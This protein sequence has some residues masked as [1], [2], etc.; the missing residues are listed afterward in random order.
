VSLRVASLETNACGLC[1]F[2][3]TPIYINNQL[4]TKQFLVLLQQNNY[5][6]PVFIDIKTGGLLIP[7]NHSWALNAGTG[8]AVSGYKSC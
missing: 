4:I 2:T 6:I 3:E 5:Y 7:L 8:A 1:V